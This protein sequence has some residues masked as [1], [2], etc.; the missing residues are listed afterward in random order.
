MIENTN[1]VYTL[2]SSDDGFQLLHSI[3]NVCSYGVIVIDKNRNVV[4]WNNWIADRS[5][6][7]NTV[8]QGKQLSRLFPEIKKSRLFTLVDNAFNKSLTGMLSH[9]LNKVPFPLYDPQ[10]TRNKIKHAI[11]VRPI[12]LANGIRYCAIELNDVTAALRREH[13]LRKLADQEENAKI[14]AEKLSHLKSG[15]ISTVSH[16]LRTPLTSIRGSLG[17]LAGG[18]VGELP[19]QS[20]SLVDI[21]QKNT[22][23]LLLLINDILDM[24][25]IESGKLSFDY[26][27]VEVMSLLEQALE[28]NAG[29]AEQHGVSIRI[30]AMEKDAKIYADSDRLMQV[31]NNLLSNAAKFSPEGSEIDVATIRHDGEI[32]ISVTD[33]GMGIPSEFQAH[34]FEKFTQADFSST[35]VKGGTGLGMSISQAIVAKHSSRLRFITEENIGTT[36]YFDLPEWTNSNNV[37]LE[38]GQLV[39]PESDTQKH[40]LV[41]EDD[42]DIATVL[43]LMLEQNG[44]KVSVANSA[45]VAKEMLKHT[46]YDAMT[47]DIQLP[48]QNGYSLYK[49]IRKRPE[50]GELPIIIVSAV[51]DEAKEKLAGGAAGISD[52]LSKPLDQGR[53]V[54]AIK[55]A[56]GAV[57]KTSKLPQLLHVEDDHSIAKFIRELLED[58]ATITHVT[59]ISAAKDL[60]ANKKFDVVLLD[61][62]LPDGSGLGLLGLIQTTSPST[63]AII[64][65]GQDVTEESARQLRET[66]FAENTD[67]K[68]LESSIQYLIH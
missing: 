25:K 35:R 42:V 55:N 17:L 40:I 43:R 20:V 6:V 14:A 37:S 11:Y 56:A 41:C 1:R 45:T 34:L 5:G 52:W 26:K 12:T 60:I 38:E 28:A 58:K 36:F 18:A 29:Y 30:S 47:L 23:R 8:A 63:S 59:S 54:S 27:P 57:N 44:Y 46:H 49:E 21:A 50:T 39:K 13:Q 32:R 24:E 53:L 51:V 64:F 67:D 68:N 31:M 65:S 22:E 4:L 15:F 2:S 61:V 66:L 19:P 33:H 7:N 62:G 10:D 9:A 3:F 16:E 48:G